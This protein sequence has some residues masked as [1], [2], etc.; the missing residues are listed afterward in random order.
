MMYLF[1]ADG[2]EEMEAVAPMDILRR[3]GM[4]LKL[5]GVPDIKVTGAHGLEVICD[6][7]PEHVDLETLKMVI[8]PGGPGYEN[9]EKNER[10]MQILDFAYESGCF[11]GAIC[12][13]P[14][15]LGRRGMLKGRRATCYPGFESQ[16]EGMIHAKEPVVRDGQIVTA[17]GPGAAAEFGFRLLELYYGDRRTNALRRKM[18][19]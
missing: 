2:F 14:S 1:L 13:A 4:Q 7:R 19:A 17:N 18:M 6:M 15:I 8:L 5:V 9:L 12:A 11:I 3:E 10:V 16:C